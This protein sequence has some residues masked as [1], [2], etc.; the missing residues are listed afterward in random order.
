MKQRNNRTEHRVRLEIKAKIGLETVSPNKGKTV[1][2]TV[3]PCIIS[4]ISIG[5]VKIAV[6]NYSVVDPKM[7]V[8]VYINI[9]KFGKTLELTGI[10]RWRHMEPGSPSQVLGVEFLVPKRKTLNRW[11][12]YA[13]NIIDN[14][15]PEDLAEDT[16]ES[17]PWAGIV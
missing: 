6:L 12:T 4:D 14:A 7:H 16:S 9:G 15:P 11:L 10:V 3:M 2:N 13:N 5:G 8:R 1:A 17:C